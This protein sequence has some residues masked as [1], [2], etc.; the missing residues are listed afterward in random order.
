MNIIGLAVIYLASSVWLVPIFNTNAMKAT[1]D[2]A[3]N[4]TSFNS[5]TF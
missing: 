5:T 3:A 2:L 4:I 1:L